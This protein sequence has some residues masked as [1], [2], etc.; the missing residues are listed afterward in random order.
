VIEAVLDETVEPSASP[1][2]E[3]HRV[4]FA[5]EA[6]IARSVPGDDGGAPPR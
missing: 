4:R 3:P 5:F 2:V 1:F 6:A